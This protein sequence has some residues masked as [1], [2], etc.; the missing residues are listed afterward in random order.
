[1]A[2]DQGF[3]ILPPKCSFQFKINKL[4][5][6]Q[7]VH[8]AIG[9]IPIPE[10]STVP[11]QNIQKRRMLS[12]SF[13]MVLPVVAVLVQLPAQVSSSFLLNLTSPHHFCFPSL[14]LV[15]GQSTPGP[16]YDEH[17]VRLVPPSVCI[18]PL[19]S[20]TPCG[21]SACALPHSRAFYPSG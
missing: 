7:K 21:L 8:P 11:R 12:F 1:M 16:A 19:L 17:A 18:L 20:T 9:H 6:F 2:T 5:G 10:T 4:Q 3:R 15:H 14:D 13:Q